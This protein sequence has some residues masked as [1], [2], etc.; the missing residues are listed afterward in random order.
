MIVTTQFR[1]SRDGFAFANTWKD[2][3]FGAVPVRGRCGGMAF[4]AR[5]YHDVGES[6]PTER[7]LPAHDSALARLIWRRQLASVF[8]GM[9]YNL[10]RFT[11]MTYRPAAGR[12]GVSALT[13]REIGRVLDSL[14]GGRPV[15][16]GLINAFDLKHLGRNHQ[17][18]AYA[19]ELTPTHALI[20]IY[21]PN[22]P[23]RDDVVLEIE[24]EGT[25]P[26]I[27]KVGER[28]IVWRGM[29]AE[30]YSPI[31]RAQ[32]G[33]TTLEEHAPGDGAVLL[34]SALAIVVALGTLR[35]VFGRRRY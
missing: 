10:W 29:F 15:P 4:A 35:W 32:T 21:D 6:I 24:R 14:A 1:P 2:V 5:D 33:A 30:K 31:P 23:L 20:R 18:L 16:L 8:A 13:R 25:G 26:V 19:A 27:E 34:V 7:A 9:G 11:Q 12:R 28:R 22:F 3:L 17:V